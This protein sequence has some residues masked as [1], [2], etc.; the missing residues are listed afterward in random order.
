VSFQIKIDVFE[1]PFDLLLNLISRQEIDIYQV[2]IADITAEYLQYLES[3][4][5]LDL[6]IATEF[7]LMA[8]TLIKLK[9]ESLLPRPPRETLEEFQQDTLEELVW[10]LLEY[11][12]FRS[13][14]EELERRLRQEEKC[15]FRQVEVEEDQCAALPEALGS[16]RAERLAAVA[17]ELTALEPELDVSHIAPIRINLRDYIQK[18]LEMLSRTPDIGFTEM[19]RECSGKLEVIVFFLALLELYRWDLVDLRQANRF[20]DIRVL[21]KAEVAQENVEELISG[22]IE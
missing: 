15:F 9:A 12:K 19:T 8:A 16:L 13:A 6:E 14:S 7:L 3:M 11:Q 20:G 18:V 22:L 2:S 5:R 17:R 4:R 1:G 10:R 21:R